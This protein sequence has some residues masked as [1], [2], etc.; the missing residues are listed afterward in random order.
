[1]AY[2]EIKLTGVGAWELTVYADGACT[3]KLGTI[4]PEQAGQCQT[5]GER[6]QGVTSRP[7]FNGDTQ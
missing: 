5:F 6:V 1:M 2:S 7:L 3:K 4:S